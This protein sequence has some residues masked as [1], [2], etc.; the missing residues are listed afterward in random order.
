ML[1]E[2]FNPE[3]ALREGISLEDW[4][5]IA[6]AKIALNTMG[7]HAP[8]WSEFLGLSQQQ[9]KKLFNNAAYGM[10]FLP[11]AGRWFAISFG[12]GHVKLD[13]AKFEQDFGLRVVLNAVD[14]Q[15][16]RSVDIRTPDE[17]TL[18]RRSQTSRGSEQSAFAID[19]EH[20]IVKGLAG[21]P[22]DTKF[23]IRVSG[24]DSL[25]IDRKMTVTDLKT[26]CTTAYT[27]Y[28]KND[29]K[30]NFPWID[31]VKYV[32]DDVLIERLNIKAI[33][34]IDSA[35]KG[36]GADGIHLAFPV[37]YDPERTRYICYK[38]FRSKT[39]YTNLNIEDYINALKVQ[40]R[41][42]FTAKDFKKHSVHE[43][44]DDGRDC[45][46]KWMLAECLVYEVQLDGHIFVLSGGRWY[47]VDIDLANEV[48][49]FFEEMTRIE[50][51]E[52]QANE[53]EEDYNK[54]LKLSTDNLLCLDRKLVTPS[55]ASSPIE[56]CDF[57]GRDKLL[58]HVKD[59]TSSSRLS[60]LFNQGTVSGRTLI[61]DGPARDQLRERIFEVQN[62]TGQSGFDEMIC[63]SKEKYIPN[64]FTVV[65]GVLGTGEEAKLPFFSL[66]TLRQ[67]ARELQALGFKSA[68]AWIKKPN[69]AGTKTKRKSKARL[70]GEISDGITEE[71]L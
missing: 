9:K 52:A 68:F 10:V 34:A 56:A 33:D 21:T 24:T 16:L 45:G 59:K 64:D 58:I 5:K 12:L 70:D 1:K 3:D 60:H 25:S 63:T 55:G 69:T 20:D 8:R 62:E 23:A 31:H 17:N 11:S 50:L 48:R 65:Y 32:R 37:I 71:V 51:P 36:T 49:A 19:I 61:L 35:L 26:V 29:Y 39:L 67:A 28:L 41:T 2:G 22:K 44:D 47:Q 57:L 7:G 18:S 6:G 27:V 42:E 30:A 14:P 66:V 38:G 40:N 15:Q 13:P 43:V 53:N 46:G 54:R 4:S